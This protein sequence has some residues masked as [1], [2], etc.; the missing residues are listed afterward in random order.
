MLKELIIGGKA[1]RFEANLGTTELFEMYT[2]QNLL[3]LLASIPMVKKKNKDG[4]VTY[5]VVAGENK[6]LL[7]IRLNKIYL[8]LAFIMA[9]QASAEGADPVSKIRDIK[10]KLDEDNYLV[11]VCQF[12][13]ADLDEKFYKDIA[14]IW[15]SSQETH[16]KPKN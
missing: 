15:Q 4:T 6:R 13:Q 9:T 7:A 5:D 10:S 11:W 16:S 1:V 3:A 12:D 8:Q 2:G 14:D